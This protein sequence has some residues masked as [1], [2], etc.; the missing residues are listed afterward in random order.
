MKP[1]KIKQSLWLPPKVHKQLKSK[2]RAE[3][4]TRSEYAA[5]IFE[6]YWKFYN[7]APLEKENG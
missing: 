6:Y 4:M 3:G 1:L 2:S 7:Y 5:R